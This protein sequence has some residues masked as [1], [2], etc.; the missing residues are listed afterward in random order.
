MMIS[1]IFVWRIMTYY[2]LMLTGF[3]AVLT[4]GGMR[5][6]EGEQKEKKSDGTP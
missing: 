1:A 4:E 6:L 2:L 5:F 3:V